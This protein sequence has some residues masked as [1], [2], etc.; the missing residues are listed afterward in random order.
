MNALTEECDRRNRENENPAVV[1]VIRSMFI[2][3]DGASFQWVGEVA[4]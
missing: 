4:F 3:E 2:N 1:Y